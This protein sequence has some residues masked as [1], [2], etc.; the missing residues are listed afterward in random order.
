M[1]KRAMDLLVVVLL[2]PFW[3]PVFALV[4]LLVRWNLGAPF[5]FR[6]PRAGHGGRAF[7][8]IKFRT[9]REMCDAEGT[10][11]PD[12]QRLS[13]FGRLLRS[14]SLDELPSLF[15]ILGGSMSLVG[16]RPLLIDYLPLYSPRQTRRH[17]VRPGL[18]GW[19][20]I[21]GRLL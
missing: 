10:P 11:L 5:L 15:N 16:P 12:H 7:V 20:Q 9:M 3:L 6:Q 21:N 2:L 18:T 4:A 1:I 19:A 17:D 8:L 13:P 14:T